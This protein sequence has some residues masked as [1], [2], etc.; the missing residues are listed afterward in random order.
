MEYA[1]SPGC[2]IRII[3]NDSLIFAKGYGMGQ[4]E[5]GIANTPT[6]A[7]YMASISKQYGLCRLFYW[8]GKVKLSLE[9]DV[10]KM[11]S[12]VPDL[13]RENNHPSFIKP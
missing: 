6:N 11:A 3:R 8:P 10:R 5:Y 7:I 1:Y 2:T 4:S 13:S 12:L 9:D